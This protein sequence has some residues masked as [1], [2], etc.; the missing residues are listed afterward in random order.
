MKARDGASRRERRGSQIPNRAPARSEPCEAMEWMGRRHGR[1][2]RRRSMGIGKPDQAAPT[3]NS[4]RGPQ[5]EAIDGAR[6][7][8]DASSIIDN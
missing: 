4:G 7:R 6:G 2:R 1:T 8:T 5:P 3:R